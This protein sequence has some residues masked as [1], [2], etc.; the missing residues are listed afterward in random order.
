VPPDESGALANA[1]I[2]QWSDLDRALV[3]GDAARRR[4]LGEYSIAAVARRHLDLFERLVR[5][6]TVA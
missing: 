3:L 2:A 6:Q 4:V 1:I 5:E